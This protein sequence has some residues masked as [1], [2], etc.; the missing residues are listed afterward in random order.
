MVKRRPTWV[1]N[2]IEEYG[3]E[4]V[5]NTSKYLVLS[6]TNCD[7]EELHRLRVE[8]KKIH[9]LHHFLSYCYANKFGKNKK[10]KKLFRRAGKIRDLQL[11]IKYLEKQIESKTK[12]E[13]ELLRKLKRKLSDR[14][15]QFKQCYEHHNVEAFEKTINSIHNSHL[16]KLKNEPDAYFG[17][18]KGKITLAVNRL[19]R[20]EKPIHT[21]RKDVKTLKYNLKV[22]QKIKPANL[23][24]G[25]LLTQWEKLLGEWHDAV[26]LANRIEKI[27]TKLK[28]GSELYNK[29]MNIRKDYINR[30]KSL[31][32]EFSRI[33]VV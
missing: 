27:K 25:K 9:A 1:M 20:D 21:L 7:E 26:Q 15:K 12:H 23:M 32:K 16:V 24:D 33:P 14:C 19:S 28:P 22:S 29:L 3:L 13:K 10:L 4:L 8:I 31:I 5:N 2:S 6:L 18:I 11:L 17:I 30:S